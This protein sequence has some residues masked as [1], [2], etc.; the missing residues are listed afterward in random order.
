MAK[1]KKAKARA[2]PKKR[3]TV[4]QSLT[5]ESVMP[6]VKSKKKRKKPGSSRSLQYKFDA[7]GDP[8]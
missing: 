8:T 1:R 4:D 7:A 6:D 3:V 2:K 5:G